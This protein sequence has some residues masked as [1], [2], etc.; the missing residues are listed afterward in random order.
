MALQHL[1]VARSEFWLAE[2]L[3]IKESQ[4]DHP[5]SPQISAPYEETVA[6]KGSCHLLVSTAV[7]DEGEIV[8]S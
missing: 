2:S 6:I 7:G 5:L 4:R 8:C 3:W 1:S